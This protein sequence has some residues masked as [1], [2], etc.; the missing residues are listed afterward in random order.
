MSKINV[1]ITGIAGTSYGAQIAK[2]L[3]LLPE[4]YT[5]FGAD[6][7]PINL[8]HIKL[9]LA[10]SPMYLKQL[11][12]V[13][14]YHKIDYIIEGSEAE[15]RLL[16]SN[17]EYLHKHGINWIANSKG[18]IDCVQDKLSINNFLQSKGFPAPKTYMA[19]EGFKLDAN[20]F[21]VIMK[22]LR[23]SSGSANVYIA[24]NVDDIKAILQLSRMGLSDF[25]IQ[26]Y[27]GT[28]DHEYTVGVL[29][30]NQ[31]QFLGSATLRRDL[32]AALSVKT[33]VVNITSKSNLGERLVVSSGVSQGL[34]QHH[35]AIEEYCRMI[36]EF[37]GSTG[38]LNFQ[39]RLVDDKFYIFE[40]NPRFS[41]TSYMRALAGLNEADVYIGNISSQ[42]SAEHVYVTNKLMCKRIIHEIVSNV[43]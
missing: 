36:A 15:Q 14:V 1:L 42:V 30:N 20:D 17:R 3:A 29:H 2:S 37:L 5:I 12:E 7:D 26:E 39:G 10:S 13:Y 43:I 19:D 18:V 31:G 24:Q 34:M 25:C 41:G 33:S 40:I 8:E 27:V 16:N 22:P 28:P 4:K 21:P 23:C 6:A 11:L 35:S 32:R 9:P 38:P